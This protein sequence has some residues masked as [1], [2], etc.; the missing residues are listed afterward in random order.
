MAKMAD[1]FPT[2][3]D[4]SRVLFFQALVD[5]LKEMHVFERGRDSL[6]VGELLV[7]GRLTGVRAG[8]DRHFDLV[9]GWERSEQLDLDGEADQSGLSK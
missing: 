7:D 8:L 6:F 2:L 9:V 5:D 4:S 3:K 1:E